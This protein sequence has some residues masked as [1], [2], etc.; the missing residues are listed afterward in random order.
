MEALETRH[1][2]VAEVAEVQVQPDRLAQLKI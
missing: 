1:L 2:V